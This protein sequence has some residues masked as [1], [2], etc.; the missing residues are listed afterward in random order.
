MVYQKISRT[1]KSNISSINDVVNDIIVNIKNNNIRDSHLFNI[2]LIL[3][4]LIINSIKHGNKYDI[5]KHIKVVLVVDDT[6]IRICVTDEGNGFV[7]KKNSSADKF[8]ETG[9]GLLL[10]E[11]LSDRLI[12]D[13]NMIMCVKYIHND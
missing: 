4:E 7:Y 10:V 5:N 11:G 1:I 8:C 2:R 6:F 12:I 9:R 3:S 13:K